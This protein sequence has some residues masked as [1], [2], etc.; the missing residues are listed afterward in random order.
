MLLQTIPIQKR[1]KRAK[2]MLS[3]NYHIPR[4]INS[5]YQHC[6]TV[7]KNY[8]WISSFLHG[9][10]YS[11]KYH[12]E[13][14][15]QPPAADHLHKHHGSIILIVSKKAPFDPST[16]TVTRGIGMEQPPQQQQPSR[17]TGSG[18]NFS[19]TTA[20]HTTT[21]TN[22]SNIIIVINIVNNKNISQ[23]P[24]EPQC[25]QEEVVV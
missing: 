13:Y 19:T 1:T 20:N 23:P 16:T 15:Q 22:S 4:R 18:E 14:L 21:T 5:S 10:R 3:F 25:I 11:N 9:H 12:N 17:P 2:G 7:L 24:E 8:R 6:K